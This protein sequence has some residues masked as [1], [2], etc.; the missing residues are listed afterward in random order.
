MIREINERSQHL[1]KVLIED[2]IRDGHP[3]G[4]RKLA[5]DSRL[6]LS[7]A[8]IRSI[9]VDLEALDL[10][11]SPHTSAGR[12]PTPKGYRMF[13]DS[14][15]TIQPLDEAHIQRLQA[16]FSGDESIHDVAATVSRL[17]SD[18]SSMA[19]VVMLPRRERL[20]LRHIEFMPLSGNRVLVILVISDQEV[21]NAIIHTQRNYTSAELQQVANC[22]NGMFAGKDLVAVRRQLLQELHSTRK[23][24]DR[25]M[26]TAI[27][28]AEQIFGKNDDD[29]DLILSGETNLMDFDELSNVET[30]RELFD[31]FNE[32][33]KVLNIL[34]QCLHTHGV[35][36]F[37]GEESGY[38]V[39]DECS[40][41]T[42][43]YQVDG[44]VLGV[45]G[46]IGPTRMAYERVIPLVD[47]TAKLVSAAL[48]PP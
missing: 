22:L 14:L 41:V 9:M 34:D 16:Q 29:E 46:I 5:Q 42:C 23:Q 30:L 44:K 17:L 10:V 20:T 36:I 2:Y 19:G 47:I 13:V 25:I 11:S 28:M 8:S 18:V 31:A 3:V 15:L 21:E 27:T 39:L 43:P 7:P 32:K 6:N 35:Q 37:I 40:M 33:R 24:M 1:L 38:D 45:L 48:N 4:S 12:V 26:R